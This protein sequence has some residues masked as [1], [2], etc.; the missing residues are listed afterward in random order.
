MEHMETT[1][2]DFIEK[3]RSE[4]IIN[5]ERLRRQLTYSY[6]DV[7]SHKG[8]YINSNFLLSLSP[9]SSQGLTSNIIWENIP[10]LHPV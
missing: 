5:N 2:N 1:M 6:K 7:R 8:N 4:Q 3:E 10:S 9:D